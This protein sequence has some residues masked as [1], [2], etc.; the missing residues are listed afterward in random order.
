MVSASRPADLER[1]ERVARLWTAE[2]VPLIVPL[3]GIGERALAYLADL[4]VLVLALIGALFIYNFWGDIE[5]DLGALGA[6]GTLL[7][8]L[9]LFALAALYDVAWETLG[10]GRTPGKRRAAVSPVM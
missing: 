8:L 10:G 7:V 6:F 9:A 1:D 4:L 3:A 5:Q 2:R